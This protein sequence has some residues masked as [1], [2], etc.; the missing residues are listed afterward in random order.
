MPGVICWLTPRLYLAISCVRNE[1]EKKSKTIAKQTASGMGLSK[2]ALGLSK[3]HNNEAHEQQ[4]SLTWLT[5]LEDIYKW[6]QGSLYSYYRDQ[7]CAK[8]CNYYGHCFHFVSFCHFFLFNYLQRCRKQN[9]SG[10]A[11]CLWSEWV[12]LLCC[13][14]MQGGHSPPWNFRS[15]GNDSGVIASQKT[16]TLY[17]SILVQCKLRTCITKWRSNWDHIRKWWVWPCHSQLHSQF[18][19]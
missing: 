3:Y 11:R 19:L 5:I 6:A 15:S 16:T 13:A 12:A 4:C 1:K 9:W 14:L 17:L 18:C 8:M 2:L 10:E 7:M